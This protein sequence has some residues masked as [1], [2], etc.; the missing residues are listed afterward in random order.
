MIYETQFIIFLIGFIFDIH[1]CT[2]RKFWLILQNSKYG[3]EKI[4]MK[5]MSECEDQRKEY[6]K[7]SGIPR[8]ICLIGK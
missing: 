1:E 5:N 3:I 7:S 6:T 2:S 8:D 4:E